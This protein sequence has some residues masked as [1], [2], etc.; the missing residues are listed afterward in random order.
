MELCIAIKEKIATADREAVV[1]C[2]NTDY[3]VRFQFDAPWTAHS[4][5]TARFLWVQAGSET[6]VDVPFSGECVS[7]PA[8]HDAAW[9]QVGVYAG[10]LETTTPAVLMCI[11]SIRQGAPAPDAPTESVYDQIITMINAGILQ[12]TPGTDGQTV[13]IWAVPER[14]AFDCIYDFIGFEQLAG[15]VSPTEETVNPG[16]VLICKDGGVLYVRQIMLLGTRPVII[17]T[18]GTDQAQPPII[19]AGKQGE[20][21][22]KGEKGADGTVSFSD[23]TDAQRASLKGD[24]GPQGNPGPQGEPGPQGPKGDTPDIAAVAEQAVAL[25]TPERIGAA[26]SGYGLGGAATAIRDWNEVKKNGWY[27]CSYRDE[28]SNSPNPTW[29]WFGK[30]DN[31]SEAVLAQTVYSAINGL[32]T[33]CK[34]YYHV[35]IGWTPW[36]WENPPISAGIEYRTTERHNGKPVYVKAVDVGGLPSNTSK[37]IA[38][39]IG[40]SPVYTSVKLFANSSGGAFELAFSEGHRVQI[41]GENI[42]FTIGFSA[43]GYNGIV[44]LKYT[45]D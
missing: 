26:P 33:C 45:K 24:P 40:G 34:R 19:L 29:Q 44:I 8:I 4:L 20:K 27:M 13:R 12:G 42:S 15:G 28:A 18:T 17:S 41:I 5:K 6:Y 25:V 32:L 43:N 39:G 21:G 30:V 16:D 36:E 35:D 14:T 7:M 38:H 11:P 1:V 9:V 37:T 3:T 22:E 31:W 2:D 10:D 23:L